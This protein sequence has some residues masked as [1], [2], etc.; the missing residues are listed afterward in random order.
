M[1]DLISIIIPTLNEERGIV[2][3]IQDLRK[4]M[5]YGYEIIVVDGL[6]TDNTMYY[7]YNNGCRLVLEKTKG[8]GIAMKSGVIHARGDIIIFIDGDRTY[9][10]KHI[11]EMLTLLENHDIVLG[12]RILNPRNITTLNDYWQF[13]VFPL[14]TRNQHRIVGL[15]DPSTGL[16]IMRKS[17]WN[18]MDLK[19]TGFCIEL[20]MDLRMSQLGL[21]IAEVSI[22]CQPRVGG[23][24]KMQRAWKTMIKMQKY[25]NDNKNE[26]GHMKVDRYY[27]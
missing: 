26:F 21:S 15:S 20:E 1:T 8:K 19:S 6:S 14:L 16:R 3:T 9:N 22:P 2:K 4:S 17:T 13:V 18:Q 25:I 27:L 11:P 5:K 10:T 7:A 23:H 24:S 12:S